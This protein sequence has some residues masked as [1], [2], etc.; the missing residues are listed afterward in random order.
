V[1]QLYIFLANQYRSSLVT[2][3][4]PPVQTD[5]QVVVLC[6]VFAGG[7]IGVCY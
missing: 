7:T 6:A 2:R 4:E 5:V 3:Q 1:R